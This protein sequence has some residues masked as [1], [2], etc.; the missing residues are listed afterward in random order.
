MIAVLAGA[1]LLAAGCAAAAA[2]G[3]WMLAL[4]FGFFAVH[5]LTVARARRR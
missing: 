4:F 3:A 2:N 1:C 5:L